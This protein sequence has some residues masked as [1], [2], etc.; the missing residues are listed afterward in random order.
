MKSKN[1]KKVNNKF[2]RSINQEV[3]YPDQALEDTLF[4]QKEIPK[5]PGCE[6]KKAIY[7]KIVSHFLTQLTYQ[8]KEL[9]LCF[10]H[11]FLFC[12]Y[13]PIK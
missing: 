11:I 1:I 5:L 9:C 4:H 10:L 2:V 7:L 3:H 12:I 8:T 6:N 13:S